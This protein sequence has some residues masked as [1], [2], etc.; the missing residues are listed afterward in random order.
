MPFVCLGVCVNQ[1]GTNHNRYMCRIIVIQTFLF[2][3]ISPGYFLPGSCSGQFLPDI[4]V[5]Q[6]PFPKFFPAKKNPADCIERRSICGWI[7]CKPNYRKKNENFLVFQHG[8]VQTQITEALTVAMSKQFMKN[9]GDHQ[10]ILLWQ[11]TV[12]VLAHHLANC[13]YSCL[14]SCRS[15]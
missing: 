12:T 10:Q 11:H 1:G 13:V 7:N 2:G 4:S 6:I 5:E 3:H 14:L 8:S 15:N 9:A